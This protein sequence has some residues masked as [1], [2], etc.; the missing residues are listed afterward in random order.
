[1]FGKRL[2]TTKTDQGTPKYPEFVFR[3]KNALVLDCSYFLLRSKLF[4]GG[5]I[6]YANRNFRLADAREDK[7][8]REG[9]PHTHPLP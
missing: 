9:I 4:N 7:G 8:D 6:T 2:S 1:M 5:N 3:K